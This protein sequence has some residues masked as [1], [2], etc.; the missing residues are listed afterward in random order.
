M[1]L[2]VPLPAAT[3]RCLDS[4]Q[5]YVGLGRYGMLLA[6]CE[7]LS[8]TRA[9]RSRTT[10]RYVAAASSATWLPLVACTLTDAVEREQQT[11]DIATAAGK[12]RSCSRNGTRPRACA[13]TVNLGAKA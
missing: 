2:A 13:S 11:I 10:A 12:R 5:A 8:P 9:V 1:A 7:A 6:Q 3:L 4:G